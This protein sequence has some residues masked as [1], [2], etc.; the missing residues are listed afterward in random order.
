MLMHYSMIAISRAEWPVI[1]RWAIISCTLR[2]RL[3]SWTRWR[4]ARTWRW[5][6]TR[7]QWTRSSE[8]S[9]R[10]RV[11]ECRTRARSWTCTQNR[12]KFMSYQWSRPWKLHIQH[13]DCILHCTRQAIEAY[14]Q[15]QSAFLTHRT[16][17]MTTVRFLTLCFSSSHTIIYIQ[18]AH[19]IH[20][21]YLG[22]VIFN[23]LFQLTG[24]FSVI[25]CSRY[26]F[27][28]TKKCISFWFVR[29]NS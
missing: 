21:K 11:M 6:L 28:L 18:L 14:R 8:N 4:V 27:D 7:I 25:K 13:L 9:L 10:T 3:V 12:M 2:P 17:G 5:Q 16:S 19:I 24:F 29:V 15:V 22:C 20:L 26:L 23:I 1:W